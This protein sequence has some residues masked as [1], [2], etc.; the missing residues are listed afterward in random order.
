MLVAMLVTLVEPVVLAVDELEGSLPP[1]LI[2]CIM[3]AD[4]AFD[5][6]LEPLASTFGVDMVEPELPCC[7]PSWLA[8]LFCIRSR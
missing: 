3:N 5:I 7:P 4:M 2:I 6:M 1:P 8:E